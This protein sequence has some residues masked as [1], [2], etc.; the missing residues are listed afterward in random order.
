M[1]QGATLRHFAMTV[2]NLSSAQFSF[3]ILTAAAHQ[4]RR[5]ISAALGKT[6]LNEERKKRPQSTKLSNEDQTFSAA[7]CGFRRTHLSNN[8]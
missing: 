5:E 2:V 4:N 3:I 8:F 6:F 7:K 1:D